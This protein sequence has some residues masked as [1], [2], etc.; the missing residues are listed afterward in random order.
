[1]RKLPQILKT[2]VFFPFAVVGF[3]LLIAAMVVASPA[4]LFRSIDDDKFIIPPSKLSY[5]PCILPERRSRRKLGFGRL[6][7]FATA[8]E[9]HW[10][11]AFS[12]MAEQKSRMIC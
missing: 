5:E 10:G 6:H 1:M 12:C 7:L 4:L 8:R 11:G 2:L 3:F 9:S